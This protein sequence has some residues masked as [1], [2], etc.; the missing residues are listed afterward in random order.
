MNGVAGKR[1]SVSVI[2]GGWAGLSAAVYLARA[3]VPVT[4]IEAARQLGGRARCVPFGEQRVDNG[5]HLMIGAYHN[6][7]DLLQVLGL[8]E[9]ALFQRHPLGLRFRSPDGHGFRLEARDLP[10]PLHLLA[11]LFSARGLSWLERFRLSRFLYR[12]QRGHIELDRDIS[13]QAFLISEKQSPRLIRLLWEPL[14]LASLNTRVKEASARLFHTVLDHAFTDRAEDSEL[15]FPRTDLGTSIPAPAF[16]YIEANQGKVILSR[17]VHNIDIEA[18]RFVVEWRE[19][20]LASDQVI[21]A[22]SPVMTRRLLAPHPAFAPTLQRLARLRQSPI[23]TVYLQYPPE[24]SLETPMLGLLE[25]TGQWVFDRA[26]CGQPGLM[27]VV[28]SGPG[29]HLQ[30]DNAALSER[31]AGELAALYPHWPAPRATRVIREKRAT[32]HAGVEVDQL[33]P[34]QRSAVPGLWLAGDYTATGLPATLEGAVLSGRR[35]AEQ[36][37]EEF[38]Q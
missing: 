4:L 15:L 37:L 26:L 28:I 11:A 20:K 1:C 5:Q 22:T 12:V 3:G 18:N 17:R 30:L 6:L 16:Q 10:A 9:E 29:E 35:C 32:F 13:A 8:R 38:E 33:R 19:G 25:S 36:I 21:L 7:L 23:C 27:A 31:V 14:C 24:V 34:D 2:G